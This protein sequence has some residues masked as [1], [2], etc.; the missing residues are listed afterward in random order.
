VIFRLRGS[1]LK[2]VVP[3]LLL[4]GAIATALAIVDD[5]H[6]TTKAACALPKPNATNATTVTA[7]T[8]A[9]A[10]PCRVVP[11]IGMDALGHKMFG[12]FVAFLLV[13]RSKVSLDRF[14]S[15]RRNLTLLSYAGV[16]VIRKFNFFV[17]NTKY[18]A[19]KGGDGGAGGESK[20]AGAGGGGKTGLR[21]AEMVWLEEVHSSLGG[22]KW[23]AEEMEKGAKKRGGDWGGRGGGREGRDEGRVFA[24]CVGPALPFVCVCDVCVC[25]LEREGGGGGCCVVCAYASTRTAERGKSPLSVCDV[26]VC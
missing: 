8:T 21:D 23:S 6:T 2:Q 24:L 20:E 15:G 12:F 17:V 13:F 22:K 11:F 19:G 25:V 9:S 5:F 3:H 14:S 4:V 18:F 10:E 7:A 16:E 26:C 1:V